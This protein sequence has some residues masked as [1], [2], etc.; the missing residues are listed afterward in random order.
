LRFDVAKSSPAA[1]RMVVRPE[2]TCTLETIGR[3][4]AALRWIARLRGEK[5]VRAVD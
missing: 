5:P 3:G 1:T 4:K 2:G